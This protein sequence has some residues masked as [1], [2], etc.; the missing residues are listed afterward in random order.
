MTVGLGDPVGEPFLGFLI[1]AQMPLPAEP[2]YITQ[3]GEDLG[4]TRKLLNHVVRARADLGLVGPQVTVYSRLRRDQARQT[5]RPGGRA[6][7]AGAEAPREH[8]PLACQA[9]DVGH[10]DLSIAL[11]AQ[12]PGR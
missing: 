8:D 12:R 2:A 10:E 9:V 11:T 7:G 5:G 6:D 1:A 4:Q 3:A